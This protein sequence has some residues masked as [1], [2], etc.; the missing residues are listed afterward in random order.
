MGISSMRRRPLR[1]ALSAVTIIL[2]TFTILLL[3][4]VRHRD[5]HRAAV[6]PAAARVPRHLRR[7]VQLGPAGSGGRDHFASRLWRQDG[8]V[9]PRYWLSPV[10]NGKNGVLVTRTDATSPIVAKALIG[11]SADE[12]RY[13]TDLARLL[14]ADPQTFAD[15]VWLSEVLAAKLGV[16]A[17]DQI[18]VQGQRLTVG[19]LLDPVRLS[20]LRDMDD[21]R[22]LPVDFEE[23]S[24]VAKNAAVAEQRRGDGGG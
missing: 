10:Q 6:L 5:G 3:R 17:G 16:K 1:T 9:C 21:S 22:F 13:R 18:V 14:A 20:V 12:L 4:V 2:L 23:Q 7:Q 8:T 24:S 11:L 19:K 15:T